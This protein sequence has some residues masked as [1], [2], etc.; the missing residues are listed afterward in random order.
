MTTHQRKRVNATLVLLV[1]SVGLLVLLWTGY[2]RNAAVRTEQTRGINER[3][4]QDEGKDIRTMQGHMFGKQE[5]QKPLV[6][7]CASVSHSIPDALVKTYKDKRW[8]ADNNIC[9]GLENKI[10]QKYFQKVVFNSIAV[11]DMPI[12]I[13][14]PNNDGISHKVFHTHNF[15]PH[16][17]KTLFP[18]LQL[19]KETSL[20]DVGSHIGI[21]SLQA[22][23][24]GRNVIAMEATTESTQHICASAREGKI[25]SK[26]TIIHNAVSNEHTTAHI[27]RAREGGFGGAFMDDGSELR[28]LKKAWDGN[29]FNFDQYTSVETVT[30]DDLLDLPNICAFKKVI[31]KIDVEG[32]EHKAFLGAKKFF[33]NVDVQGVLMEYRWHVTRPSKNVVLDFFE[34][35]KFDPFDFKSGYL[36]KLE[37]KSMQNHDVLWLPRYRSVELE[38]MKLWQN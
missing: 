21:N 8:E 11:G 24:Y 19:D 7:K 10:G 4:T 34:E 14:D 9:Q 17:F 30:L 3:Q 23:H 33:H 1:I 29:V 36:R 27:A 38:N 31:I 20:L 32:S 22:A 12:F 5:K 6:E 13:H 28:N 18:L 15:E 35:F 26:M 16:I 25:E 37:P 2:N